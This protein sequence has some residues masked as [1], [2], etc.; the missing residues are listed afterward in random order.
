MSVVSI[1][2]FA[3]SGEFCSICPMLCFEPKL[4]THKD[5]LSHPAYQ[6]LFVEAYFDKEEKLLI[7]KRR[8][9]DPVYCGAGFVNKNL[10][11]EFISRKGG[12][13]PLMYTEDDLSALLKATFDNETGPC[14]DPICAIKRASDSSSGTYRTEF[15]ISCGKSKEEVTENIKKARSLKNQSP[16][17][18]YQL[19]IQSLE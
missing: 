8:G 11:I 10:E 12:Y 9:K 1:I 2:S 16:C 18:D 6:R 17:Q 15:L 3:V 14:I 19:Y 4:C 13:L 5:Y 7:F